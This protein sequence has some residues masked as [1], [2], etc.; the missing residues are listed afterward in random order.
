MSRGILDKDECDDV[1]NKVCGREW[2]GVI[3]ERVVREDLFAEVI[4]DLRFK[5][6]EDL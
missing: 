3:L 4:F 2:F 5:G 1:R 6:W